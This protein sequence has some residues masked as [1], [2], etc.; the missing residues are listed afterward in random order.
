[1]GYTA[2][3]CMTSGCFNIFL[4]D[5]AACCFVSGSNNIAIGCRVCVPLDTGSNQL[6]IG[7][8]CCYWLTGDSSY[9][10][11][12]GSTQPQGKLDVGGTIF[13]NQLSVAG[14]STFTSKITAQVRISITSNNGSILFGSG[15]DSFQCRGGIG[16]AGQNNYHVKG[17]SAGDFVIS[18]RR[19]KKL[20]FGTGDPGNQQGATA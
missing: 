19:T 5:Q 12:I 8:R 10:V 3:S 13:A 2:A 7:A 15:I 1:M 16:V 9:N 18:A 11:G 17:T 6:A 20:V 14:F 4:G